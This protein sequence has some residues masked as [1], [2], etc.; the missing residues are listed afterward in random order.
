[1][2]EPETSG[3]TAS[4]HPYSRHVPYT[5]VNF[6]NGGFL[7]L[8]TRL[9]VSRRR[10]SGHVGGASEGGQGSESAPKKHEDGKRGGEGYEGTD[11][12]K[13]NTRRS[14][15]ITLAH[16]SS[17]PGK[18]SNRES[19]FPRLRKIA[20]KYK[21]TLTKSKWAGVVPNPPRRASDFRHVSPGE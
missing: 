9:Q 20:T 17:C 10:L 15:L 4:V 13:G 3:N 8:F 5:V 19:A 16:F 7:L 1:M 18:K 14:S 21:K 6:F 12:G 2:S 11:E